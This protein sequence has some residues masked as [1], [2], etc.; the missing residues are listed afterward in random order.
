MT[1]PR[2]E[3]VGDGCQ[4]WAH[5]DGTWSI[6]ADGVWLPGL[7]ASR[8]A[9]IAAFDH[10]T[11]WL[12]G[13]VDQISRDPDPGRRTITV[14]MLTAAPAATPRWDLGRADRRFVIVHTDHDSHSEPMTLGVVVYTTLAEAAERV[15]ERTRTAREQGWRSRYDVFELCPVDIARELI[16]ASSLGGPDAVAMRAQT[17]D[18]DARR[19]VARAHEIGEEQ[20]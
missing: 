5:G 9:A 17:T 8:D 13:L 15:A 11:A 18:D 3:D 16:E 6:S 12:A 2:P 10:P 14:E 19:V 1:A 4:V 20:R 7:Y